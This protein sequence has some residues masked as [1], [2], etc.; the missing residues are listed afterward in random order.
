M[1]YAGLVAFLLLCGSR[2]CAQ[3][4]GPQLFPL[5]AVRLEESPFLNA[6]ER[7]R[8]Y[9][10]ALDPDRLLAPYLQEAGLT[11]RQPGYG[12]WEAS[13]LG[14]HVGGHYVSALAM[15]Y[16]ATGTDTVRARLEYMLDGL[17][18][19][20]KAGGD[21]YLGG[22]PG[23][24]DIWPELAAGEIEAERFSLN[25]K[26]VPWY[27]LHKTFA[28][29]R[30]AWQYAGSERA[31]KMFVALGEWAYAL[32][33]P[34][35]DEQLQR[36]VYAEPGGM[37]ESF[38][39]LAAVTGDDKFLELARRFSDRELLDPLLAGESRLTGLHANTQIPK[40]IGYERIAKL[41]GDSSW[42]RAARDFWETVVAE[43]TVAIGGNSVREH[44]HSADDFS[45]MIEDVQGPETCNTYNMLRLSRQ[46]YE[47]EG[48]ARYL[49]YYERALYNHILASQHPEHGGLV[50][51]TPMRP[52][53]YRVYS[54]P[55]QS[56]WCCV[57][58]GLENH[59]KYGELIYAHHGP[60]SLLVNLFIPST[61]DWPERGLR[62]SQRNTFPDEAG[63]SLTIKA[64]PAGPF[65]VLLRRP[66]W[67]TDGRLRATVNGEPVAG[68]GSGYVTIR[69]EWRVGDRIEWELPMHTTLEGLPDGSAWYAVVHGPLVMA[70]PTSSTDLDGLIA[71]DS[72]MGHVAAGPTRPLSDAPVLVGHDPRE[73]A[74]AFQIIAGTPLGLAAPDVIY[75]ATVSQRALI[76]FYRVHDTRYVIY[77]RVTDRETLDAWRKLQ[78]RE[79]AESRRLDE[80]T[81]DR[82]SPGEQQPEVE[83]DYT[84]TMT[85]SGTRDGRHWRRARDRFAY[86]LRDHSETADRLRVTYYGSDTD[87]AF[88]LF[89][90]NTK[91]ATVRPAGDRGPIFYSEEYALPAGLDKPDGFR[92]SFRAHAGSATA[93]I[94][95]V[96]LLRE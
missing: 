75:P 65:T 85:E 51:F 54:S 76:P 79:E 78:Q 30:D 6:E 77:W 71:D 64:A 81:V 14:G 42:H 68:T 57:G 26:W 36:I 38:A 88:D 52:D 5:S 22:V 74:E 33:A 28:G 94:Y 31:G 41:S 87:Y 12:N 66:E 35:T 16:A 49:A 48:D 15:L 56:F 93:A 3:H 24:R 59:T 80:R 62:V 82:V 91:V 18:R 92:V 29:L 73:I 53:H 23:G 45:A 86:T 47:A 89:V 95:D 58:S 9:L 44:F 96:R 8:D 67:A 61:L 72:R 25:G 27:N 46:L 63:S 19:A 21:G 10:L 70:A 7:D 2:L 20:Q 13:G 84:G 1:K 39:D 11:P 34:L 17:E 69:R 43:R 55:Q 50:Y 37:N 32:L 40:V 4:G 90:G 60:D 83:H